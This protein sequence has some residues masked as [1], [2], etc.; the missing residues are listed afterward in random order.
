MAASFDWEC[1]FDGVLELF[2]CPG[3]FNHGHDLTVRGLLEETRHGGF[4]SAEDH[5]SRW[6]RFPPA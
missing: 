4:P 6:R 3:Q 5:R 2:K 1:V